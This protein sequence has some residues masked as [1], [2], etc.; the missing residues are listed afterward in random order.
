[1]AGLHQ[2]STAA[3]LPSP[4]ATGT[5]TIVPGV[6]QIKKKPLYSSVCER[7][8]ELSFA[9]SPSGGGGDRVN[10]LPDGDG[11]ETLSLFA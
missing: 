6:A 2:V 9:Q 7:R 8:K 4:V 1:M 10:F 11:S 3:V 5:F